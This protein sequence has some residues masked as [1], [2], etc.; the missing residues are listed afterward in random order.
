MVSVDI[1][2]KPQINRSTRSTFSKFDEEEVLGTCVLVPLACI[3]AGSI[4][5]S[6][7]IRDGLITCASRSLNSSRIS[8][9]RAHP[10][11]RQ[12]SELHQTSWTHHTR[13]KR[14]ES[15]RAYRSIRASRNSVEDK[16]VPLTCEGMTLSQP[17]VLFARFKVR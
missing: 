16:I 3:G 2:Q 9:Y 10:F 14:F 17:P 11:C 1:S 4:I 8:S 7:R 5:D 12:G 15:T 13:R 6:H